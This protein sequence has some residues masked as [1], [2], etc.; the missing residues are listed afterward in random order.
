MLKLHA[1]YDFHELFWAYLMMVIPEI[2][3]AH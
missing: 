2:G 3:R 1:N